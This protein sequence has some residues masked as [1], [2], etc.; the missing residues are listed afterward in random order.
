MLVQQA[1]ESR[2]CLFT[3]VAPASLR[4]SVLLTTLC[5][6]AQAQSLLPLDEIEH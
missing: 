3:T 1:F 5:A 4:F 2:R 6:A